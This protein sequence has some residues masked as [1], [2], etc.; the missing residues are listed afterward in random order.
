MDSEATELPPFPS[1]A[2]LQRMMRGPQQEISDEEYEAYLQEQRNSKERQKEVVN[3]A[4]LTGARNTAAQTGTPPKINTPGGGWNPA[5]GAKTPLPGTE[6][7][8]QREIDAANRELSQGQRRR[9]HRQIIEETNTKKSE[10][11]VP[12][13][14]APQDGNTVR[15]NS[16]VTPE[17]FEFGG[18]SR[19]TDEYSSYGRSRPAG[20]PRKQ[21]DETFGKRGARANYVDY[22][23]NPDRGDTRT[24]EERRLEHFTRLADQV[25]NRRYNRGGMLYGTGVGG[26]SQGALHGERAQSWHPD[27][28][29]TEDQRKQELARNLIDQ[30]FQMNQ[31]TLPTDVATKKNA[32][33]QFKEMTPQELERQRGTHEEDRLNYIKMTDPELYKV[34]L[35]NEEE[36]RAYDA[37]TPAEL[38][39]KAEAYD[40]D[41]TAFD[42]M[43]S[44][45]IRRIYKENQ[46]KID[47]ALEE[48]NQKIPYMQVSQALD[49]EMAVAMEKINKVKYWYTKEH[50]NPEMAFVTASMLDGETMNQIDRLAGNVLT[51][52]MRETL[53]GTGAGEDGTNQSWTRGAVE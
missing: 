17:G 36:R 1:T 4:Q 11:K 20:K 8:S 30:R 47:M 37:M 9:T 44:P 31:I 42:N 3:Q 15:T 52:V 38:Y 49:A 28:I 32:V 16:T 43:T 14:V 27:E 10:A 41:R 40:V 2:E 33:A 45:M 18:P 53:A 21:S 50:Y 13:Q 6:N 39:R 12:G 26:S 35:N 19:E 46:A 23:D 5:L 22:V 25:N 48:L 51:S 24:A 7:W 34:Y 29:K